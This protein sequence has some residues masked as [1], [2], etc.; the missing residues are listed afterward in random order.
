MEAKPVETKIYE[1]EIAGKKYKAQF[2]GLRTAIRA[3]K[4]CREENSTRQDTEKLADYILSNVIVEPACLTIEDF[5]NFDELNS[6]VAFG[7]A[8]LNNTF[9]ESDPTGVKGRSKK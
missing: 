2:Y 9:R 7:T 3:F 1:K 6:V 8:V 5:D 4:A